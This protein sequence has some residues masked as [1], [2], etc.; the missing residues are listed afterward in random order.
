M[1]RRIDELN[2]RILVDGKVNAWELMG[3]AG[4]AALV[5]VYYDDLSISI[6]LVQGTI[7]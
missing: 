1:A 4:F 2:I 6:C 7:Y 3:D 5:D